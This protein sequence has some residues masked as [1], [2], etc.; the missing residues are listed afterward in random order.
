MLKIGD[1]GSYI[2]LS[3]KENPDNLFLVY[4][5]DIRGLLVRAE[6]TKGEL[7]GDSEK[8]VIRNN[9]EVVAVSGYD[10]KSKY[11]MSEKE[12]ALQLMT[13]RLKRERQNEIAKS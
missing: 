8:I 7:L 4:V 13:N 12:M 10:A 1:K 6:E 11:N 3:K 9:A 2:E 5:P